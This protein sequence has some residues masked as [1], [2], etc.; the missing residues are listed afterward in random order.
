M[1]KS[2]NQSINQGPDKSNKKAFIFDLQTDIV[3]IIYIQ[4]VYF[5]SGSFF[6][7]FDKI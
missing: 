6:F 1:T 5:K 2:T 7:S 4:D 3:D